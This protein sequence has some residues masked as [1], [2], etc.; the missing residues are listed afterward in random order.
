MMVG[1]AMLTMLLS[2]VDIKTPAATTLK[3]RH[4]EW[5]GCLGKQVLLIDIGPD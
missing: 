4:F 3:T 5:N 1:R 2:K